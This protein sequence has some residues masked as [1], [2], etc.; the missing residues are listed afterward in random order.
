MNIR[1]LPLRVA[2]VL[3]TL[4]TGTRLKPLPFDGKVTN[5]PSTCFTL[6]RPSTPTGSVF[7][8][9]IRL[10]VTKRDFFP[11]T[12]HVTDRRGPSLRAATHATHAANG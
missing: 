11:N 5:F 4:T 8:A 7:Y 3:P 9:R 12:T 10:V 6:A 1:Y 2:C